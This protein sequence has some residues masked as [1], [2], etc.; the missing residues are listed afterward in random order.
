M[1]HSCTSF[2]T[3][4]NIRTQHFVWQCSCARHCFYL[5]F[6][7]HIARR[8][9]LT[10]PMRVI[11]EKLTTCYKQVKVNT[12]LTHSQWKWV[13]FIFQTASR[14]SDPKKGKKAPRAS[15]HLWCF[16]K[17]DRQWKAAV[18]LHAYCIAEKRI[19][20]GTRVLSVISHASSACSALIQDKISGADCGE[21]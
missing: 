8:S 16:E 14:I 4:I 21:I 18:W 13:L 10:P 5:R 6:A 3:E 2:I 7:F 19:T 1:L 9:T 15:I 12:L 20:S 11:V 17:K